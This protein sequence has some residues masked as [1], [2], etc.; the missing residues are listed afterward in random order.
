MLIE[1]SDV[2]FKA[3]AHCLREDADK[4]HNQDDW[5]GYIGIYQDLLVAAD[6]IE[7]LVDNVSFLQERISGMA[8]AISKI[9]GQS[10]GRR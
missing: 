6:K 9:A 3:L 7:E 2:A 4:L 8:H 5:A 1:G 10:G